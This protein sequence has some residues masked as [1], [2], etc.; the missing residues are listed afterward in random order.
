V[1]TVEIC[2]ES[3]G[4]VRAARAAG[5]GRVELCTALD[6]GGLTPSVGLTALA[7]KAGIPVRALIRPRAGDFVFDDD[8]IAVMSRDIREARALGLSG[9]VIGAAL[10]EGR[11][12]RDCLARLIDTGRG[13]MGLTLHR[14]FDLTPDPFEALETAV[15]L[16]FDTILT[17][18]QAPTAAEGAA[19]LA[20]L[21]TAAGD[22][23]VI[24]AAGGINAENVGDLIDATGVRAIHAS[25]RRPMRNDAPWPH[26]PLGFG[27]A[28]SAPDPEEMRRLVDAMREPAARA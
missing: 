1:I 18:G 5:A 12:D 19:R 8:E 21:V 24:L 23:V 7:A 10:P 2:V 15:A 13:G 14:V 9:V 22:R 3:L 20:R 27:A 11:L 4:G 17:S 28:P 6:V 16:G 26:E 25:C